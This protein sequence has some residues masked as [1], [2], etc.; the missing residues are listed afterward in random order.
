[1]GAIY[2]VLNWVT[3]DVLTVNCC[4]HIY[5]LFI[6]HSIM[7]FVNIH[8]FHDESNFVAMEKVRICIDAYYFMLYHILCSL[9]LSI[10]HT[11]RLL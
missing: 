4:Q 7:H 10:R 11:G 3:L 5:S 1:M 9:H 8:L 2:C 6:L